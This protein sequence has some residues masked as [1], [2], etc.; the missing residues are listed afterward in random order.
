MRQAGRYL[1]EY[2]KLRQTNSLLEICKSPELASQV[3]LMPFERFDLD[4]AIIFADIM[5]PLESIGIK[6]DIKDRIGPVLENP[7]KSQVD[8]D[9]LQEFSEDDVSYLSDSIRLV[10]KTLSVPLIGFSGAPFTLASYM[11]EGKPSKNFLLTKQFMYNNEELW[12][13]I[14]EKLTNMIIQYL[15][16]QIKSGVD[17]I[18]LFD[19]WVGC[20]S[21]SDYERY[22][23]PYTEK[24]MSQI[25][26]IP[27][28]H[29]GT[30]TSMLL[31]TISKANCDVI[32]IDWRINLDTAWE[33]IGYE[34]SIQGNLDPA[35]L[36]GNQEMVQKGAEDIL[37]RAQNRPG[38]IFN[39]GHGIL[40]TTPPENVQTL[41][42]TVH[43]R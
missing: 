9:K 13:S 26:N 8:I 35:I 32:G 20:L 6:F 2:R 33:K 40:P 38:H 5:L 14:M 4:A 31:D 1:P 24:I 43:G 12:A 29:F 11:I 10:K 17:A 25:D 18:Q 22:V 21:P 27:K 41:I 36:L 34:K 30:E 37:K 3:T 39:L 23:F 19:S 16:Y 7:I 15:N 28:I 42:E